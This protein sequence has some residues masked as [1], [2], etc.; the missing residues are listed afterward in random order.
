MYHDIGRKKVP[1]FL[2]L[3]WGT[4]LSVEHPAVRHASKSAESSIRVCEPLAHSLA[5]V[6]LQE[7]CD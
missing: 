1:H 3:S 4:T 2:F 6:P 7:D 5:G